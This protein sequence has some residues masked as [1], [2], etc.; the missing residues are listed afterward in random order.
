VYK[1]IAKRGIKVHRSVL[2]RIEALDKGNAYV[3]QI[4]PNI[5]CYKG[6]GEK[7][8]V[9]RRMT[10]E[11]WINGTVEDGDLAKSWLEWVGEPPKNKNV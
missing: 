6:Q 5:V 2:T 9:C 11:E 4:R 1:A 8:S 7:Q 3:P 10:H